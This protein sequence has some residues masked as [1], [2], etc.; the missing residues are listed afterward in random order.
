MSIYPQEDSKMS[1]HM[2]RI[3]EEAEHANERHADTLSEKP[4]KTP[5]KVQENTERTAEKIEQIRLT[6]NEQAKSAEQILHES[7]HSSSEQE[8]EPAIIS[9][10]IKQIA[11][12]RL[13]KRTRRHL[14]PYSRTMS[15][16]IHQPVVDAVSEG[17]SKTVGR[18]SGIIGG[19]LVALVGTSIYYYISHH[20]GYSYNSF[21]FLLLMLLGFVLGWIAEVFYKLIK[22]GSKK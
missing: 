11:Y 2:P 20:Y 19:G 13:L 22:A 18:P 8:D 17:L 5:E 12:Q 3:G 9:H 6:A 21:I 1:E 15:K 10:E 14:S 16:V 7:K 4:Q